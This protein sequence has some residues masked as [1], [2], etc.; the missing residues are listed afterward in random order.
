MVSLPAHSKISSSRYVMCYSYF[1]QLQV[2]QPTVSTLA[3]LK[4]V[5]KTIFHCGL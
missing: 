5:T 2:S 3:Q 1:P 4:T